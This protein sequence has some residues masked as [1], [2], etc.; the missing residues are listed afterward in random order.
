[1]TVATEWVISMSDLQRLSKD[2]GFPISKHRVQDVY[3][4]VCT[5]GNGFFNNGINFDTFKGVFFEELGRE[6]IKHREEHA[7]QEQ[8]NLTTRVK[9]LN[10][11]LKEGDFTLNDDDVKE[12]E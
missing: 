12:L 3:K 8:K 2:F 9:K 4:K 6:I 1:M 7:L 11:K 5:K 10:R